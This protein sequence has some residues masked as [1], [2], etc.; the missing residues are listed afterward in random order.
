MPRACGRGEVFD[1]DTQSLQFQHRDSS[2]SPVSLCLSVV[3]SCTRLQLL[4]VMDIPTCLRWLK[5]RALKRVIPAY[6]SVMVA[7][8]GADVE[9]TK[10]RVSGSAA[11]VE[12]EIQKIG[13]S[14]PTTTDVENS[15]GQIVDVPVLQVTKEILEAVRLIPQENIQQ[16]TAE[17]TVDGLEPQIQEQIGGEQ[18]SER[19]LE[20]V[21]DVPG[22]DDVDCNADRSVGIRHARSVE[23]RTKSATIRFQRC[24]SVPGQGD[25]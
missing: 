15:A 22:V 21:R 19:I 12:A 8:H 11:K 2:A 24:H 1:E 5:L 10:V 18:V 20:R 23:Q 16:H 7:E 14:I 25:Q 9:V 17:E 3:I 6:F 4:S 13:D